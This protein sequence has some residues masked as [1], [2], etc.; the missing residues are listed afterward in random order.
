MAFFDESGDPFEDIVREFFGGSSTPANGARRRVVRGERE[1]RQID[2][3][4]TGEKVY[5]VFEIPGYDEKEVE[6]NI[7]GNE[8]II[9]VSKRPTEKVQSYLS[10]KLERG[11]SF[12]KTLPK[13]IKKKGYSYQVKNGVLEVAFKKK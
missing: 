1:D 13:D 10:R 5:F 3:I 11:I 7:Q 12:R 8:L 9:K 6:L 2:Y 4:D